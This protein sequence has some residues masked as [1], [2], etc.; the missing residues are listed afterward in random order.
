[1]TTPC[2][3]EH[4]AL[5]VL[6]TRAV[7]TPDYV[8]KEWL[9]LDGAINSLRSY[10]SGLLRERNRLAELLRVAEDR[11]ADLTERLERAER[12]ATEW[13]NRLIDREEE[14]DELIK[15]EERRREDAELALTQTRSLIA[16]CVAGER[17]TDFEDETVRSVIRLMT[18]L[19]EERAGRAQASRDWLDEQRR[20]SGYAEQLARRPSEAAWGEAARILRNTDVRLQKARAALKKFARH[21][22]SCGVVVA[23]S[24]C[25]SAPSVCGL[26]AALKEVEDA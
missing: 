3:P 13:E 1:M 6:W 16:K 26:E 19:A 4:D 12:R 25:D 5:H 20:A 21:K 14:T 23:G 2:T 9:A 10:G 17:V 22:S 11:S 8:K 15:A 24:D 7:G 18:Q